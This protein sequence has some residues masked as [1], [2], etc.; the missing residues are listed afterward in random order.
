[1]ST[2][3]LTTTMSRPVKV[4]MAILLGD[5]D[6]DDHWY[7]WVRR[8]RSHDGLV[9]IIIIFENKKYLRS[10]IGKLSEMNQRRAAFLPAASSCSSPAR[11]PLFNPSPFQ[12]VFV[13]STFRTFKFLVASDLCH[14]I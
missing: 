8:G 2:Q 12:R 11:F 4:T 9:G 6:D 5:D 3:L 7:Y 13:V 14:P 10:P 1:M